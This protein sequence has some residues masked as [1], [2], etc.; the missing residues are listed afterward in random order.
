MTRNGARAATKNSAGRER[1]KLVSLQEHHHQHDR[2]QREAV[3]L[4]VALR[5]AA[6]ATSTIKCHVG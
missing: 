3:R 1:F 2:Q 5:P 4:T 6:V